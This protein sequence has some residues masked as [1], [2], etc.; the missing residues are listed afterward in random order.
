MIDESCRATCRRRVDNPFII[1][2][3]QVA[4]A[5]AT[6]DGGGRGSC[7]G[8]AQCSSARCSESKHGEKVRVRRLMGGLKWSTDTTWIR[9][10]GE[11]QLEG[12]SFF[13]V[14]DLTTVRDG[15]AHLQTW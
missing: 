5:V 2:A 4:G 15:L 12:A 9:L 11:Q 1:D 6:G 10:G 8:D 13:L 14:G 7:A 3:K